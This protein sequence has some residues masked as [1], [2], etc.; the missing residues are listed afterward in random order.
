[1]WKHSNL[2]IKRL[3]KSNP[4]SGVHCKNNFHDGN[5]NYKYLLASLST[6]QELNINALHHSKVKLEKNYAKVSCFLEIT[7]P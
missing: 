3:Q 1:M 7:L 4:M 6:V 5:N 2:C